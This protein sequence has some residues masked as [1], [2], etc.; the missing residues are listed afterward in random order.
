MNKGF[1]EFSRKKQSSLDTGS[2]ATTGSNLF[3]GS[4][5]VTGNLTVTGSLIGTSS[6][7]GNAVSSSYTLSGS[8]AETA[9]YAPTYLPLTGGTI[10]GNLTVIGTAS[11]TYTTASSV[12]VGTNIIVLNT[13]SPAS[14]FGG[15]TVVDS[16]SFGNSSTGSLFWDSQNNRWIYSNPS[17]STYDGGML[18][19]GPRNTS[20]LGN[21]TGMDANF[22]AVGA[23]AD[24]IRPGSIYNSG[25]ITIITGSLTVT[26]TVTGSLFG[27]ASYATVA[28]DVINGGGIGSNPGLENWTATGGT[29]SNG[30]SVTFDTLVRSHGSILLSNDGTTW[31]NPTTSSLSFNISAGI[32]WGGTAG[33][34]EIIKTLGVNHS[35]LGLIST[36]SVLTNYQYGLTQG[37]ANSLASNVILEP[38][39]SFN[40]V[41]YINDDGT[42]GSSTYANARLDIASLFNGQP[43]PQGPQGPAVDTSAFVTTASFNAFTS[44]YS[45][46]SFTGSF[47]GTLTGT[48][49]WAM[50]SISSSYAVT[51]SYAL[52]G[53]G[54]SIDT[55]SL[56]TTASFNSY[57]SSNTSQFAGTAS[58][59]LTASY[60]MNGGGGGSG[61]TSLGLL[62]SFTVGLQNI[63]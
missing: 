60:A 48:S 56:L 54:T 36:D 14:R 10:T 63:F 52:N 17:G 3:N 9:S 28:L 29:L 39:E 13:D 8:Y 16:G 33:D 15:I 6:W 18:I 22:I 50:N 42:P 53:G 11:F 57:T 19:S 43:G 5:T 41:V 27:T 26:E 1:Y 44:S 35:T 38:N 62:Q 55:G 37:T 61:G 34:Y 46:G 40:I 45:T 58:Y 51:A 32:E 23:G 25:S 47:I 24:H 59:A 31:T 2:F 4:Q 49:S 7:A 20:G 12:S 21:E 30:N